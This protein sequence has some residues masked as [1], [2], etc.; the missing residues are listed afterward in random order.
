MRNVTI[1][2]D[3]ETARWARIEAAHRDVSVSRLIGELLHEHMRAQASY[4]DAMRRY[5]ARSPTVL[6]DAGHYPAR[7]EL[8]DRAGLR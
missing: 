7:E 6:K 5:L 1:T 4:E 2:L 8:H 3:E